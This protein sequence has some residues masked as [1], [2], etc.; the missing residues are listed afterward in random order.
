MPGYLNTRVGEKF[1]T[2]TGVELTVVDDAPR[3]HGRPCVVVVIPLY[4]LRYV[5]DDHDEII[6]GVCGQICALNRE[7]IPRR[8]PEVHFVCRPC[9]ISIRGEMLDG[10]VTKALLDKMKVQTI[11]RTFGGLLPQ[12]EK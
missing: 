10:M 9:V 7:A 1:T 11:R 12:Q 8:Q 2:A 4:A 3:L 5:P 6:C